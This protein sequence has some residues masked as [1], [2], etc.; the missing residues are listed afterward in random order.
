MNVEKD[1]PRAFV[2]TGAFWVICRN[3]LYL[4]ELADRGI[5]ILVVTPESYR[6]GAEAARED[7][8]SVTALIT[9]IAYVQGALDREASFNPSVVAALQQWQQ[10]YRIVGA[11]AV[12]ETLVEP[13]GIIADALGLR[14]PGLR[15]TRVC[16]SKYLQRFYLSS[17][18]PL[19]RVIAPE[20]R[21][22][23]DWHTLPWP[24]IVKP[25]TR[26]SSSGVISVDNEQQAQAALVGYPPYETLLLEQRVEGQEYSVES[27]VQ[28]G[29]IIFSSVTHKM[30]TDQHSNTFVELAHTVPGSG[31]ENALLLEAAQQVLHVL[32]FSDGIAHSEWRLGCDGKPYLM[33]IAARTPG[34]GILPL[35]RLACGEPL[36]SA[37]IKI[38]LGEK[39]SYPTPG[40]V[41]RQVYLEH[42]LG[43]LK[44]VQMRWP[45]VQVSWIEDN[46]AWPEILP[47]Q[48]QD[49]PA[50]RAVFVHKKRG[51]LLTPLLSS[52]DR[53]VTFFI[54]ASYE[55]DLDRL[56]AEVRATITVDI[57]VHHD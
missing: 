34:D 31:P 11:F 8:Q 27:L 44:D 33:E 6:Q 9:D 15:A 17:F 21:E 57:E 20:K 26:H 48:P 14:S 10:Q 45:G 13:T 43:V 51:E 41:A 12:G 40:R 29:E 47:G 52:D 50:L 28:D 37:I 54:D 30:T 3:S 23:I 38:M 18:S 55:E 42:S 39:A 24:L 36:E 7:G 19:S 4:R 5:T 32:A 56:E 16:R 2:L 25:A 35:Y 46:K 49:A 53:A 22:E 1:L